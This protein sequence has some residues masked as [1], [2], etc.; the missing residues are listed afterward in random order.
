MSLVSVLKTYG[1]IGVKLLRQAIASQD[2]TGRTAASIR[3][4]VVEQKG[5]EG[6]KFFA[7]QYFSA[8]E[9][10]IRPSSKRPSKEMI[11]SMTEYARARGFTNPEKAAWAISI[12]QLEKGD[13]THRMGGRILY[14]DDM[15]TFVKELGKELA[16]DHGKELAAEIKNA[17][18]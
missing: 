5:N 16:E 9:K 12:K 4:E 2:A 15:N 17:F 8:L 7:R 3:F 14:S 6:L 10:G 18:K 1:Q 13:T 11:D